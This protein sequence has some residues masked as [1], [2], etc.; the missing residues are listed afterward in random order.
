MGSFM[1]L[2][3]VFCLLVFVLDWLLFY[4]CLIFCR[5]WLVVIC[6]SFLLFSAFWALVDCLLW[7][8]LFRLLCLA[9]VVWC[10][11]VLFVALYFDCDLLILLVYGDCRCWWCL[12]FCYLCFG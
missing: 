7:C 1:C 6:L 2:L 9:L 10:G 11:V 5:G 12:C 8:L 3:V 4:V